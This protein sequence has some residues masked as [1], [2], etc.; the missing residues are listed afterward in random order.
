MNNPL[1]NFDPLAYGTDSYKVSHA[2]FYPD[3]TEV[4]YSYGEAR[5]G[6][7]FSQVGFFGFQ[8]KLMMLAGQFVTQ[9]RIDE[10]AE[11][12]E[13]HFGDANVFNRSGWE[14]ILRQHG[15]RLPVRIKAIPEGTVLP[16][17]NAL[18]TIENTDPNCPWLTNWLETR[19]SH[20][21]YPSTVF[22]SSINIRQIIAGYLERTGG[23][24]GLG[25]KCHDF[26]YRGVTCDEQA[27]IG[28]GAHLAA[29]FMGTDTM[30]A[31]Y[32]LKRFYN[33]EG[34][35]AF[36]IRATEH[37]IMTAR[38][39]AGEA[40]VVRQVLDNTPSDQMVAMVGDS[41]DMIG[42]VTN[43]LALPDIKERIQRR[44]APLV[45]RPDS[46]DP[47]QVCLEVFRALQDVFGSATNEQG[48][49]ILP[50]Y[51]AMIQGDGIQW[52]PVLISKSGEMGW[53]H[54]IQDIL[55]CFEAEGISASN[56]AFGSGGGLIQQWNRDHIR[57]AIKNA[58]MI[59]DG[60]PRDIYKNPA[61]DPTK[62][63]KRGRLAVGS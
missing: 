14:H 10:A 29:G 5:S 40:D 6:G 31:L 39:E 28:G 32:F 45:V 15:G 16:E 58:F 47:A 1:I 37:S 12:A 56:I 27:M 30:P 22:T 4:V 38:G 46:G 25:F 51:L 3:G 53:R 18:F 35:P 2:P 24:E 26:G 49:D 48:Y 33:A 44:T 36:S 59:V 62:S 52:Y 7:R 23:I 57:F 20:V 61:T 54:T 8:P 41:F 19:L 17:S 9:E 60:E 50:P 42:F 63:S 55:D 13:Q 21:W 43:I 34:M 11:V